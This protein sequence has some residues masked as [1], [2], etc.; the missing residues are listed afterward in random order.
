MVYILH[1]SDLHFVHKKS[2]SNTIVRHILNAAKK[3]VANVPLGKKLLIVTGDFHNTSDKDYENAEAF[4]ES[5]SNAMGLDMAQDVFVTPGNHD[6]GNDVALK[7][8]LEKNDANWKSHLQSATLM[9][10]HGDMSFIP[11]RLVAFRPYSNFVR[12]LDIYGTAEDP[13]GPAKTYLR[14]WRGKLNILHL[15]TALVSDGMTEKG[16]QITDTYAAADSKT[17]SGFYQ[18]HI[19]AIA[20]GHNSFYDLTPKCRKDLAEAFSL[21]NVSS[22]L[23]GGHHLIG[24]DAEYQMISLTTGSKRDIKIPNLTADKVKVYENDYYSGVSICWHKWDES[25]GHVKI[26]FQEWDDRSAMI[27]DGNE[28]EYEMRRKKS[29][30]ER[31]QDTTSAPASHA[32]S[33]TPD[34]RLREFLYHLLIH[35]RNHH[36]GFLMMKNSEIDARLFPRVKESE[37]LIVKGK[38]IKSGKALSVREIIRESWS[39]DKKRNI[40]IEGAGGMGKTVTLFSVTDLVGDD[41]PPAVYIPMHRLVDENGNFI[42]ISN[43]LISLSKEFG[44]KILQLADDGWEKGPKLLIL[45]DGFN[46][47]PVYQRRTI[48]QMINDWWECSGAQ[49]IIA[50]RPIEN[51][52]LG[53]E[54]RDN[55]IT[56]TLEPLTRDVVREYL[57]EQSPP[58]HSPLWTVLT[59]PLFL[60]MYR[61]SINLEGFMIDGYSLALKEIKNDGT[62]FWNILQLELLRR[63]GDTWVL[64]CAFTSEYILPYI[65]Y[66]MKKEQRYFISKKQALLLINAVME[67]IDLTN[68]PHHLTDVLNVYRRR[69]LSDPDFSTI[70]WYS[71]VLSEIGLMNRYHNGYY[72]FIHREYCDML[73]GVYLVNQAE[74]MKDGAPLPEVWRRVVNR[75]VMKY[76][77]DL[78]EKEEIE[79]LWETNRKAIPTDSSST[80]AMLELIKRRTDFKDSALNFSGMNLRE[81]NLTNYLPKG[82]QG[83]KYMNLF[84]NPELSEKTLF[85]ESTFRSPGHAGTVN[86]IG[87]AE[88]G[89]CVSGSDDS[90][91]RIWDSNTGHCLRILPVEE[92]EKWITC[93][94]ILSDGRI[95]SGSY[96]GTIRVWDSNT[97]YCIRILKGHTDQITCMTS[98]LNRLVVSGSYDNTLRI[99]DPDTGNCIKVLNGHTYGIHCVTTSQNETI[100]SGSSDNTLR[101]WDTATGNCLGIL[102]GHTDWIRCVVVHPNGL[103]ISGSYDGTLRVWDNATYKCKLSLKGHKECIRCLAVLSDGRVISGSMDHTL[104]VWDIDSGK[105]LQILKGHEDEISCVTDLLDGRIVSGS[106][107]RTLRVWDLATGHCLQILAGHTDWITCVTVLPDL[108]IISGSID[109]TMRIW[110]SATGQCIWVLERYMNAFN[111]IKLLPDGRVLSGSDDNILRVWDVSTGQCMQTLEGHKGGLACAAVLPDGRVVSGSDDNV[112]QVWDVST[113]RCVQILEGHKGKLTSMAVLSDGRVVC[114][115]N[116]GT[117]RVWDIFSGHCLLLWEGH[118]GWVKDIVVCPDGNVI[119]VSSDTTLAVWDVTTGECLHRLKG[120]TNRVTCVNVFRDGRVVSCSDDR[121]LRI[122]DVKTGRCLNTLKGHTGWITCCSTFLDGTIISGSDDTTL[123]VWDTITGKCLHILKDHKDDIT[124]VDVLPDGKVVSGSDDRTLRVWD[125]VTGQCLQTLEGH[126][127]SVICLEV[128]PG[129]IIISGSDDNTLRVW[130]SETGECL[131]VFETMEANVSKMDLSRAVLLPGLA[132]TLWQNGA[133]ISNTDYERYVKPQRQQ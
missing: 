43:Y 61:K 7:P 127:G 25:S 37:Q 79:K 55:P 1:I 89:L 106:S 44:W 15:N 126:N 120:H 65:A 23:T 18:D 70:D 92:H 19:P 109:K 72:T 86:C 45:L 123:R 48:L 50:T 101:V 73:A 62:L 26:E 76:V 75:D 122:W 67:S 6:I 33:E 98:L 31:G 63:E 4:L 77:A 35:E 125:V 64:R 32:K 54:L 39:I 8:L 116:D 90:T 81:L 82:K 96:D 100:I 97:G 88:S 103:I 57:G 10:K 27:Q 132:K 95:V 46:E 119:S 121:T 3:K 20:I 59:V 29:G 93:M 102:E 113:G 9:L 14:N 110:D 131:N 38:T 49:L 115:L 56:I 107:D 36:P 58:E 66:S 30:L 13:D 74:M 11:E 71:T 133:N 17:W 87:I 129:G 16:N 40:V 111:I 91:L 128:L 28:G 47:V 124:C 68:L 104:R 114:G 78:M 130:D 112:L 41:V 34:S 108:H 52:N 69:N 105:C 99:W 83:E 84:R 5:L 60:N 118:T 80:Y 53:R 24:H 21:W 117:L 85:G 12:K 51:I 42:S 94:T 22:F 2:K